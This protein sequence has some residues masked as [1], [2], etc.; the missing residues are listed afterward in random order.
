MSPTRTDLTIPVGPE[1]SSV[2]LLIV[3]EWCR[4]RLGEAC[5][6]RSGNKFEP[7]DHH[8]AIGTRMH[9]CRVYPIMQAYRVGYRKG[10]RD[11]KEEA[12]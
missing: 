10:R 6:D 2:A 5:T 8:G 9:V 12:P 4:S 7:E 3:C 11:A 1:I